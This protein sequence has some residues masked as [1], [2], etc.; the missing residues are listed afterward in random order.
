MATVISLA[1]PEGI[2]IGPLTWRPVFAGTILLAIGVN[3]LLF[4]VIAKLYGVSRWPACARTAGS[5]ST[6]AGSG[7]RACSALRRR[8]CS[9][10]GLGCGA[11]PV[12]GVDDERGPG[13]GSQLAALAQTLMIVGAELGLAGFLLVTVDPVAQR[14]PTAALRIAFVYDALYPYV[15]AAPS[16][17][18]TSSRPG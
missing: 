14:A 1:A 10:A 15:R 16:G 2:E 7:S 8:C 13:R 5:G 12:R 4:G 18:S 6:G 3:A 9:S 11:V 17:G